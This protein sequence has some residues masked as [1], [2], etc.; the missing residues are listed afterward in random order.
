MRISKILF[1]LAS[2]VV[3]AVSAKPAAAQEPEVQEV[4]V[5]GSR[6]VRT[7]L[8]APTPV[9]TLDAQEIRATGVT[10][11]G[12]VLNDLPALRGTF[13]SANSTRFIGTAG[14]NHL[15]LRG[16]GPERTL[17]LV[18]GRRHVSGTDGALQVDTNSIPTDLLER[19][20]I[21]TG[22]ASSIYGS[23]AVAGV[24]NFVLKQNFEGLSVSAQSGLS[25][26][27]DNANSFFAVTSGKNFRDGGANVAVS[28]E[29]S[30]E[31][32]FQMADR[33][34]TRLRNQFVV[35]SA[36]PTGV[37][38]DGI[39]DRSFF[40][41]VRSLYITEGGEFV[42][43]FQPGVTADT[44]P[45][46]LR[47]RPENSQPKIFAFNPDGTLAEL[48]YGSR[49]FRPLASSSVGG[50]ATSLRRYGDLTPDIER[51]SLNVLGHIDFTDAVQLFGEAKYVR[52][53]TL[54]RTSPSFNQTTSAAVPASTGSGALVIRLDN[55][56]LT[57]QAL[58]V[59][60]PL[61][62]AGATSFNLNR[63]NLD[64][65]VRG[66]D[67]LRE[68]TRIVG[69][70]KGELAENLN[71]EVSLNYGRLK[72][73]T[74]VLGNR[75]ERQLRLSVDAARAA[76]G[77]IVC[78]S[79]LNAA[80]VVTP[81]GDAVIDSC[82]PVNLLGE[83]NVTNSARAYITAQ[84]DFNATVKQQVANGFVSYETTKWLN[85][86]G[87][88][89]GMAAGLEYRK[90]GSA[91]GYSD[92][93]ASGQTFLNAIQA[94]DEEYSVKEAFA[95]L[96]L[97]ILSEVPFFEELT[98][99][100]SYRAADYSLENTSTV[101][102]WN[103]GLQWAPVE[104][105]RFR[106]NISQSV[107]APTIGDLFQP[108]QQNFA[109]I[110]DPCD[111][112]NVNQG[113]P[114]RAANCAAA[115]IPAG[116]I[117]APARA[118]FI[119]TRS[120]GNPLLAEEKSRSF[121]VGTVLRP[122]FVPGLA[123]TVDYYEIK[124]TDVI[125]SVTVQQILDNCYDAASLD[126]IYCPLV[127]RDPATNFFYADGN[128]PIGGGVQ[129]VTLNY[130]ARKA[131]GIDGEVSYGFQWTDVGDFN[132][133]VLGTYVRQ[134]DNYPFP[135]QPDRPDQ[136]LQE[137]GDPQLAINFELGFSRGPLSVDYGLRWL[138]TQYVDFIENIKWVG[139]QAPTN[140]D[141]SDIAFTGSVM[142]HDMRIAYDFR[143]N[144]NVYL[145]VDNISDKLPP[146]GYTGTTATIGNQGIYSAKGRFFYGGLKW[147]L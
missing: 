107:R 116:F 48:D 143:D 72:V 108:L 12:D 73:H 146:L 96:R 134:R 103:G 86:P 49:D 64:L 82:I 92:D 95:E 99:N 1:A 69:G 58:S 115:G 100:G 122:R 74:N 14:V 88:P 137:V 2:G 63:N 101:T 34:T 110:R 106:A 120:G 119:E 84:S 140:A 111:V 28:L 17:V 50:N 53:D 54:S 105:V 46:G 76:N 139:G 75:F 22:G 13:T 10:S 38:S 121:T 80:G 27:S 141:F 66:E 79:R 85:L 77:E 136:I 97:P 114:T 39:P 42:P 7:N 57:S 60:Q 81:T 61:L 47:V 43:S 9:T 40:N 6:I 68:T 56:Y 123:I 94:I 83:G 131:R 113:S 37:S 21:V 35:S 32:A 3:A 135:G 126:N 118:A 130:A 89:I 4:I 104:D 29:W 20:D 133:R 144:L 117:N 129:Q 45:V 24:V 65:G 26:R 91:A 127:F 51:T 147:K 112:N 41:D 90:E 11:I 25:S 78:R 142:Y 67:T 19:V 109:S 93:V 44:V 18:N 87:G 125:A 70:V 98:L 59:I 128:G 124:I 71:Y 33:P 138:E 145:G 52:A 31:D 55:P 8:E 16:L 36:D 132:A 5:T 62:P 15:D 102:A 30:K 23:D